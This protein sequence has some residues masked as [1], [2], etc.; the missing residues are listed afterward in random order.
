VLDII[1]QD[2]INVKFMY[3]VITTQDKIVDYG[4]VNKYKP[5]FLCKDEV[6]NK[7]FYTIPLTYLRTLTRE[8]FVNIFKY[9]EKSEFKDSLELQK[10]ITESLI[11]IEKEH[12]AFRQLD[13]NKECLNMDVR[14]I[15]PKEM[16][17]KKEPY[18]SLTE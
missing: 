15:D 16:F 4:G 11:K 6:K 13:I 2:D 1:N 17:P 12:G 14:K 18:Y 9:K 7:N 5:I 3:H 10:K 8:E